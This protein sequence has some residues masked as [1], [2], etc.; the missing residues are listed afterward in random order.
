MA[1][2]PFE[3]VAGGAGDDAAGG[4]SFMTTSAD[5]AWAAIP[6]VG[7]AIVWGGAVTGVISD[8]LAAIV[9]IGSAIVAGPGETI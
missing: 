3:E 7:G 5:G 6:S 8:S 2:E 9:G 1:V 4:A